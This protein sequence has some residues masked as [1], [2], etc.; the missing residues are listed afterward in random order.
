MGDY[1]LCEK[2]GIWHWKE[3]KCPPEY[4][5]YH[6]DYLDEYGMKIHGYGFE[7]A[8]ERYAIEYNRD[9]CGLIDREIEVEIEDG[10]GLRKKFR[11]GAAPSVEYYVNE[12]TDNN[13]E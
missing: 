6:D 8:A 10:G 7:D 12:I 4:T 5:V 1:K 3:E 11:L 9:D 2:C 13:Y